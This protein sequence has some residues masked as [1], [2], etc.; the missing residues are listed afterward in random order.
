MN[1]LALLF[2]QI[3]NKRSD[4]ALLK[5]IGLNDAAIT[6]I[7]IY[8]GLGIAL[9]A[10][11]CGILCATIFSFYIDHYQ[12]FPLPVCLRMYP[13]CLHTDVLS[14]PLLVFAIVFIMHLCAALIPT[15]RLHSES[16]ATIYDSRD[17]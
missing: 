11:S 4:I 16:L 13:T 1:I 8:M 2:M 6:R 12:L 3:V 15:R 17:N 5:T 9:A 7:F 10:S 14:I